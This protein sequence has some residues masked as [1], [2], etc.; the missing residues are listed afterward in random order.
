MRPDIKIGEF[1]KFHRPDYAEQLILCKYIKQKI[2][3]CP[4][5]HKK[6]EFPQNHGDAY[7]CGGC[8]LKRQSYGN[9]LYIW[10]DLRFSRKLKLLKIWGFKV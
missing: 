4:N 8:G 2:F 1:Q 9:S 5:C 10:D 6:S 7:Q 3:Y